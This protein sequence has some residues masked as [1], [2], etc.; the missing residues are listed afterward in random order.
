MPSAPVSMI[1]AT[2]GEA[3]KPHPSAYQSALQR[4]AELRGSEVP[5]RRVL[6]IGDSVRTDLASARQLGVDALFIALGIHN[7]EV[8]TQGEIEWLEYAHPPLADIL[9]LA[10][11]Q[12]GLLFHALYDT[13]GLDV[14]TAQ[15]AITLKGVVKESA[16]KAAVQALMRRHANLCA[17]FVHE[18]R[19]RRAFYQDG[20]FQDDIRMAMLRSEWEALSR[21][22]S[23]DYT[24]R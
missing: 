4:A 5:L 13:S 2:D 10:P 11:L 12:E 21:K 7:D 14:Y 18:G 15:V 16:L 19:L 17:G 22:R 8:L 9:P 23:W 1:E 6:A 3:G 24:E 20:I